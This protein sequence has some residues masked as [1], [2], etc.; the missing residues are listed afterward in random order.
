MFIHSPNASLSGSSLH[1]V[2]TWKANDHHIQTNTDAASQLLS[3]WGRTVLYRVP[4]SE[5]GCVLFW[6]GL[7]ELCCTQ[8]AGW[9]LFLLMFFSIIFSSACPLSL[10][11]QVL[12]FSH[13]AFLQFIDF[14]CL[15]LNLDLLMKC[16]L[17]SYFKSTKRWRIWCTESL[18]IFWI[19]FV[20][21]DLGLNH[22]DILRP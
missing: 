16:S 7:I 2:Q 4:F 1:L 6:A 19:F 11:P 10:W 21:Q 3:F 13:V 17:L 9:T 5:S 8:P 14:I 12:D 20:L 22:P 15:L 18:N